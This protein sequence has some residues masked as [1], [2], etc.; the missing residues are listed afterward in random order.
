MLGEGPGQLSHLP[1]PS[2]GIAPPRHG[3]LTYSRAGGS[4]RV[5]M[6][7]DN[8]AH[9]IPK[10]IQKGTRAGHNPSQK[11]D[12]ARTGAVLPARQPD[13]RP[14]TIGG[15]WPQVFHPVRATFQKAKNRRGETCA[16]SD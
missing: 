5:V 9:I 16:D 1:P 7:P 15:L 6:P 4:S 2:A 14:D 13:A 11:E 3:G 12:T 8:T 10:G